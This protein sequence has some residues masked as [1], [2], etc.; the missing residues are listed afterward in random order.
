MDS[1]RNNEGVPRI[2]SRRRNRGVEFDFVFGSGDRALLVGEHS[3]RAG[4]KNEVSYSGSIDLRSSSPRFVRI[5]RNPEHRLFFFL[6]DYVL[7]ALIRASFSFSKK[8]RFLGG[9]KINKKFY[10]SLLIFSPSL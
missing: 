4:K 7:L 5:D 8:I 9:G 6:H 3:H 2:E 1:Q 10:A